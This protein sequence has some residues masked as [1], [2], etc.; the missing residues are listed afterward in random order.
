[1]VETTGGDGV[2][3]KIASDGTSVSTVPIAPNSE[4]TAIAVDAQGTLYYGGYAGLVKLA[5]GGTPSV[6]VPRGAGVVT[7]ANPTVPTIDAIS[8]L[9]PGQLIVLSVG[10]IL[11]VTLP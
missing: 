5:P 10:Q 1:M 2:I 6:V 9:A 8:V 11:K 7:G 4:V 3:R